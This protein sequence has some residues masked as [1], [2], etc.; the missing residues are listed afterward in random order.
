MSSFFLLAPT[1]VISHHVAELLILIYVLVTSVLVWSARIK[2]LPTFHTS[3]E[4]ASLTTYLFYRSVR[5]PACVV[6]KVCAAFVEF[7]GFLVK[8]L[9]TADTK[10]IEFKL[11]LLKIHIFALFYT[12]SWVY[13]A[14]V[15]HV[16][17]SVCVPDCISKL[18][19]RECWGYVHIHVTNVRGLPIRLCRW[20][21]LLFCC[22]KS[23]S[24]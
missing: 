23:C 24:T 10:F 22:Y 15:V 12:W 21:V 8:Q 6:L 20:D 9:I 11:T 14:G 1:E 2:K 4:N 18:Y 7:A 19:M 17:R 5:P 13:A 16:H 3:T